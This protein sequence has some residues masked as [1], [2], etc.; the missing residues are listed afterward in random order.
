[1]EW[2]VDV[3]SEFEDVTP[4]IEWDCIVGILRYCANRRADQNG[5]LFSEAVY[6]IYM[7]R[8]QHP[9][10]EYGYHGWPSRHRV[11]KVT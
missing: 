5:V 8:D 10:M 1:M 6:N 9:L 7:T 11:H 4:M 3:V 2:E